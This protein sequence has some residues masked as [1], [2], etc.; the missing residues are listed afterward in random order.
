MPLAVID[1]HSVSIAYARAA[2]L[3]LAVVTVMVFLISFAPDK[4]GR[5]GLPTP[6]QTFVERFSGLTGFIL[7][8]TGGVLT[9]SLSPKASPRDRAIRHACGQLL[10]IAVDP[11]LV[12]RNVAGAFRNAIAQTSMP[13]EPGELLDRVANSHALP[14][15][16]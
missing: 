6:I 4:R 1:K 16:A 9:Y 7:S 15:S 3:V 11:A 8:A 12:S 5:F 13:A 10:G 2:S 14:A